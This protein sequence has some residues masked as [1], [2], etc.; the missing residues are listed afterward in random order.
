MLSLCKNPLISIHAPAK[1]ATTERKKMIT[2]PQKFQS[3]LPRRERL[4]HGELQV[5]T[6]VISIHAPAKGATVSYLESDTYHNISIHAPAKGA[7]IP[8][9]C[10]RIVTDISIHAPAKGAT[11]SNIMSFVV[12]KFQSTLP[13]RE[14]PQILLTIIRT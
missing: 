13:R 8:Q 1:G 9:K 3:T 11:I 6:T 2:Q 12:L 4:N 5:R 7:T 10:K 14:R